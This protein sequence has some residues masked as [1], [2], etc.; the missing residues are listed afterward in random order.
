MDGA[1]T[2]RH[3]ELLLTYIE[4]Y[5]LNINKP[6]GDQGEDDIIIMEEIAVAVL[7]KVVENDELKSLLKL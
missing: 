5:L 6:T 1:S 7:E 2:Q 4:E 3:K